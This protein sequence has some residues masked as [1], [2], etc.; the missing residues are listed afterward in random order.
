MI[1]LSS[2]EWLPHYGGLFNVDCEQPTYNRFPAAPKSG[3]YALNI[4]FIKCVEI[5]YSYIRGE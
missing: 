2:T 1:F 4:D 5:P 3:I